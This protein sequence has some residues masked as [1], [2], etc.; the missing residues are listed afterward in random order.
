MSSKIKGRGEVLPCL[1]FQEKGLT[2]EVYLKTKNDIG[3]PKDYSVIVETDIRGDSVHAMIKF[4][5]IDQQSAL[6]LYTVIVHGVC[7]VNLKK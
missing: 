3:V 2:M 1:Y 5:C 6:N 4:D 7:R